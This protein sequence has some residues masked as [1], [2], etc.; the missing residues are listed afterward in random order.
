[1]NVKLVSVTKSCV[2]GENLTA[3]ELLVYI[4]RVS[5]PS[6]QLNMETS[7]KLIGYMIKNK[8]WSPFDMVNMTVEVTTSKAVGIQI[9]RHWSIKPQE[10][11]ISGDSKIKLTQQGSNKSKEVTISDLYKRFN[12]SYWSRKG[13]PCAR[14]YDESI[15]LFINKEICNVFQTGEKDLY[16][17]VLDT[18]K[19]I[20]ATQ[21][22]KFL[23]KLGFQ[24]LSDIR[25]GDFVAVNGV[26]VY[27]DIE[28]LQQAKNESLSRNGLKY[29]AEKAGVSTHTIRKWL[30]IHQLTYTK[31]EVAL[32]T[33]AWNKGLEPW[34][35]PNYGKHHNASVRDKMRKSANSGDKS[36]FYTG[37][38]IS[39]RN[40][41]TAECVKH[42]AFLAERQGISLEKLNLYEV[43]HI[44]P[45]YSHPEKAFDINNLQL[46]TKDA[47]KQKSIN[48]TKEA[49]KTI[50]YALVKSIDFTGR[51]MTYDLE[52]NHESHNYV[53]NGIVTHN[54]QRYAEVVDIEPIE[55]RKQGA[56]NR[57]VGDEVFDPILFDEETDMSIRVRK[58]SQASLAIEN[59]VS[60]GVELYKEL[61]KKGVAK[62]CARMILPM[63]TSTTLYLNGSV[64]SWIHYMEQ[65]CSS[66]AQAEHRE[67]A[68][69]IETIFKDQFPMTSKALGL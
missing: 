5:N 29:I 13:I 1:M 60:Q 3:E 37:S 46:L 52:V 47:H 53:A 9:L 36:K 11:C 23:T 26:S 65:R 33:E 15:K 43:D 59:Y 34:L 17:L 25:V 32:Y 18:G 8:H 10:F 50:R 12:S 51:E 41:V 42:K 66:H 38:D 58:Y 31:K 22:H 63:A 20:K 68:K 67:V 28:W 16:S 39:W 48:E 44:L 2:E 45:I 6:N 55:L 69:L 30:R 56:T 27:Q 35:Q 62:E 49:R 7:D 61:L 21:D 4:A 24:K 54:S 19:K 64:R 57:Q 40:R 14:V